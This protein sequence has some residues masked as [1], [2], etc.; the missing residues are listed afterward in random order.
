MVKRQLGRFSV[1]YDTEETEDHSMDARDLILGIEGLADAITQADKLLNGEESSI[2]IKVNAPSPGSLGLPVEV[3]HY[4]SDSKNVL[5]I[6]GLLV[7][8]VALLAA[9]LVF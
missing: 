6:I 7:Q 5:E 4:L 3:L 9:Y 1:Y 8:L 2:E